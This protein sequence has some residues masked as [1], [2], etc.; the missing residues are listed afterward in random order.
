MCKLISQIKIDICV[1][2]YAKCNHSNGSNGKFSK[3]SDIGIYKTV[4]WIYYMSRAT[5]FRR[6]FS[7]QFLRILYLELNARFKLKMLSSRC[8]N[9]FINQKYHI[10]KKK[11]KYEKRHSNS[12]FEFLGICRVIS[13][14]IQ[15]NSNILKETRGFSS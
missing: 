10:Q 8:Q 4:G 14:S 9:H 15:S 2:I 3:W 6:I 1:A 5:E 13:I 7:I 11:Q 12:I